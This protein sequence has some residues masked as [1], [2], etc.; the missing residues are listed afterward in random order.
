MGEVRSWTPGVLCIQGTKRAPMLIRTYVEGPIIGLKD[1]C[2]MIGE[3]VNIAMS[4][5][6]PECQTCIH[7]T[8]YWTIQG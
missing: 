5:K 6:I 7:N 1:G 3:P 2:V 4:G 8:W